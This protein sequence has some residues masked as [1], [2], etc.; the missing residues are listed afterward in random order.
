MT[1]KHYTLGFL[2]I[3][4]MGQPMTLRL[5]E[6]G[7]AVNV[8]NRSADKL[9]VVAEAGAR[10]C[11]SVAEVVAASD[12]ILM[13]LADTAAVECVVNEQIIPCGGAGKLL[14]DLSS[15]APE[16]TR[17]LASRLK[18][19]CYMRWVDAPVSG[20]T[21]GAEQGSLAIMAGGGT[22]DIEVAR[23]VLQP[24][25]SRLTHMG[26][27][28]SGQTTKICN[29]M[30]V[31]CNVLVI[32]EMMALA[33]QAGVESAK[34]P[35]ALAGGFADSKP[36]QIVGREMA[37]DRFE[38]VKWRVKTLLKDLNMAGDLAS[39]HGS[40]V[41]MSGLAAQL[42]QLHGSKGFLEQDPSTLIKLYRSA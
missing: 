20:G 4:L 26:P 36:L 41:P 1:A 30:I 31:S 28:G 2:G 25:Y 3:G 42:M 29:Q 16:T 23:Q 33:E 32:A 18:Q 8:W 11:G 40:A 27:V 14:I 5:L 10:V 15:I 13:C 24:L 12:V 21:V 19:Q 22:D 9:S 7:F 39:A 6:A 35:E 17:Q 37:A 34:I 38:P